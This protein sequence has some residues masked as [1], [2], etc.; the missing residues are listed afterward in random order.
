MTNLEYI[1]VKYWELMFSS[2]DLGHKSNKD[3]S[4]RCPICGDS[5]K[6]KRLKR[7]HLFTKDT[8]DHDKIHCFNCGWSGN[9]YSFLNETSPRLYESYV[10]ER[11]R[12]NLE[13]LR[14]DF[15]PKKEEFD[16]SSID[17][18]FLDNTDDRTPPNKLFDKP[19]QFKE[20]EE[21]D[22]FYNYLKSR[23]IPDNYIKSFYKCNDKINYNNQD[24]LLENYIIIPLKY[25]NQLYGFQARSISKKQFYTFIP[26]ENSGFKIWNWE[27]IDLNE[28]VYIFESVFDAISSGQTNI[29]SQMGATISYDRLKEIKEPIFALDNQNIDPTA[30]KESIKYVQEG[31][32]VM[33]WPNSSKDFKDFN[34]ILEKG[35][36]LERI[37]TFIDNNIDDGL[38]AEIKL[39]SMSTY[40]IK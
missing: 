5:S 25:K 34:K 6:N 16:I 35:A 7:C 12:E 22:I 11:R 18:S 13:S 3:Y 15:K 28:P 10:S 39:K 20:I 29:L 1:N 24:I 8:W 38:T 4:A 17:V 32:K 31:Y 19:E 26:E 36:S 2:K 37:K 40:E 14:D 21:N 23:K 33:I 9:M 27:D 30:N